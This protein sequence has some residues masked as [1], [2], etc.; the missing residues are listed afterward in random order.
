[1]SKSGKRDL[2]ESYKDKPSTFRMSAGVE[3]VPDSINFPKTEEEIGKYWKE[4]DAFQTSLKQSKGKPLYT[5]Y[6]GPPF[7]TGKPHY[8]HLLAG[9]IKVCQSFKSLKS[10]MTVYFFFFRIR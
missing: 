10:K 1:M 5:F 7:A 9:T 8:G 3:A 2:K 6:D 4:I